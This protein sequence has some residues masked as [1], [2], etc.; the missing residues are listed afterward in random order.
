[1]TVPSGGAT[2]ASC[3][4]ASRMRAA[5]L[6]YDNRWR[7]RSSPVRSRTSFSWRTRVVT[8]RRGSQIKQVGWLHRTS[9]STIRHGSPCSVLCHHSPGCTAGLLLA[10]AHAGNVVV[11]EELLVFLQDA[12]RNLRRHVHDG[13]VVADVVGGLEAGPQRLGAEL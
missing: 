9:V 11:H 13:L 6:T 1:M 8:L 4:S 2:N 5:A 12:V 7:R 3:S 10:R